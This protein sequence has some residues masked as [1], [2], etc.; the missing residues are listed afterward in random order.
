MKF[1]LKTNESFIINKDGSEINVDR[2]LNATDPN[3]SIVNIDNG[4][5]ESIREIIQNN[6]STLIYYNEYIYVPQYAGSGDEPRIP[7]Y[8]SCFE[9]DQARSYAL[10]IDWDELSFVTYTLDYPIITNGNLS[11]SAL[12][13]SAYNIIEGYLHNNHFYQ[14]STHLNIVVDKGSNNTDQ[15]TGKLYINLSDNKIYRWNGNQYIEVSS[16][17]IYQLSQTGNSLQMKVNGGTP[18]TVYTPTLTKGDQGEKGDKGDKGDTGPVGPPVNVVANAGSNIG[19]VG[20]PTVTSSQ[21]GNDVTLT[22]N[23]LKGAKGDKG[24]TGATPSIT[25]AAGSNIGS[26]G[27]PTVTSTTSGTTTTFTFNYLKGAKGDK[28]D[29]GVNATT[30]SAATTSTAGLM[31]A[32]DKA[33][34]DGIDSGAQVN[35]VTS[36]VG[37]EGNIT[38]AQ[39]ASAL[40]SA[41]HKLTDT[42]TWRGVQLNGVDKLGN[43]TD[44]G[45]LN[46]K[47]G[48]NVNIT[49]SNGAFTFNATDTTYS[50]ATTSTSGLMSATDKAKL[51]GIATGATANIGTVT[52]VKVGSTAYNPASGVVS[53]PAYPTSLPASN[54]TSTYSSTGTAPVNGTAV[55]SAIA[56]AL[57]SVLTY[58]GTIG[59]SGATVTALPASHKT[60][61]VYVVSTN[62]TYAGK[63]AEKGDFIIC[64]TAGTSANDSHWDVV[65][66]ENEVDNKNATLA[67]STTSTIATVDGTDIKVTMPSSPVT[68]IGGQTGSVTTQ[69]I[70]T[71]L[72]N[73]G[74]KLTDNNT[75]TACSTTDAGYVPKA[76]K[77]K[78]LHSNTSTGVLEWVDDNNTTYTLSG[79]MGSS[80]IGGATQPIYWNGSSFANTTYT[81][82]KSVPSNAVFTDTNTWRGI[83]DNLTSSTNTTESLS[84]K[85]GYLLANG[86]ARDNTKIPLYRFGD[87]SS[88]TKIKIKIN[89]TSSWMLCFVVTLYQGYRATKIMISGYQYG[90]NYWY[91]P[92]ARLIC[93]S[94]NIETISVYFGYDSVNNLWVGFDGGNYTGVSI[95]DVTN[96]YSQISDFSNLFTIS[97]V[98]SLTT[99]QTTI[100]AASRA[101]YANSAG[102]VAWSN[103]SGKPLTLTAATTGFTISGGTTSKTLT[104]SDNYSLGAAC[105]KGVTDN[106]SNTDVTSS[107]TNLITGRTLYYQLAKKGYTTNTGT[108]TKVSAGTGL[109]G[110]DITTTGT[111]SLATSGVTAGTYKRVTVDAYGR[112]T[113]GDNTD[114]NDNTWRK[115]QLNGTD[116]LENATNT[117][118]LN[119]KAGN[120]M[121]I[122]ESSGTFTFNATDTTYSNATTS[123]AG[124]M[125]STDKAKLDGIATGATAN[126]GTVTQVKV[127]STAYNPTNGVISLPTYPTSLPASDTTSNYSAT[128]TKPVNGTAV[129][130]ALGT[131]DVSSVGGS[132]K[133]IQSI[134]E[135]DGK[136]SATAAN[137]PS[138]L[139]ASDT[140]S[141]YSSTGTVPVNGTAVASALSDYLPLSGGNMDDS[142]ELIIG[143]KSDDSNLSGP[144][145]GMQLV[146][147]K[148]VKL[149][150]S[151]ITLVDSMQTAHPVGL[152][153]IGSLIKN[154]G[155]TV[156]YGNYSG[157][158]P[159]SN[160]T[161]CSNLNADKLDGKHASDFL[162][163]DSEGTVYVAKDEFMI[164]HDSDGFSLFDYASSIVNV[165]S[166]I[167]CNMS[168][169]KVGIN[170][171]SPS[172]PLDVKGNTRISGCL[173][174]NGATPNSSYGVFAKNSS[175]RIE[176]A[177]NCYASINCQS[178]S[179]TGTV[180]VSFGGGSNQLSMGSYGTGGVEARYYVS[181]Q[182]STTRHHFSQPVHVD[183]SCTATSHPT[184]SDE[185]LKDINSYVKDEIT[186][187]NI[188]EAPII[189]YTWKNGEEGQPTRIGTIAQYWENIIPEAVHSDE[190]GY[191]TIE[192]DDIAL[193]S[194]IISA[195][196]L[197]EQEEKISRLEKEIEELKNLLK[198]H[199]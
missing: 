79:L 32:T 158:I 49:E 157:I 69:T 62:G 15:L 61:D 72:T 133:Y 105:T 166:L 44:T 119:I 145:G 39:I 195:R 36:V 90:S 165:A 83:Q 143:T 16:P 2:I 9:A 59:S 1:N 98:S 99:L 86:S 53:L 24:D 123:V 125:S 140:T 12:P 95:N 124:L 175:F 169:S 102:S 64:N 199:Q 162:Q 75:W 110:G 48:S 38:A 71:L 141:T 176:N 172:Y 13:S 159:I 147:D 187:D 182:S 100:T 84:A 88:T 154:G 47:A 103:V 93:D 128:G 3:H 89:S 161:V 156:D 135:T 14:E 46:I 138:S 108:V 118:P 129:A 177:N 68:S 106:S 151:G 87:T 78:F 160:G 43:S 109:T 139:P 167:T 130:A 198:N 185:R 101:N 188:A 21:S 171:F 65:N 170:N 189:K 51:D 94:D 186:L 23:Y 150:K 20:T 66:G 193:V 131:L 63:S 174:L 58:K 164:F 17:N 30:T 168:T 191:L 194:S 197:K 54:T 41:N 97:N 42:N 132:G 112:V 77:G 192:Y 73:A 134:S 67:W 196:K 190:D 52:Q 19:L 29:P 31:S 37:K 85:Q 146:I 55:A 113:A 149:S 35:K 127:G 115:I 91:Q 173:A 60:G 45:S 111:I 92:E 11:E 163:I 180:I 40:V 81:L 22:F 148:Y 8:Y 70:A 183:G 142:A 144:G 80:A 178:T 179:T 28:G 117:N 27:T 137:F 6:P 184:S 50:N 10:E 107:D 18:T 25:S 82:G 96:G 26:V 152:Y 155:G 56:S 120:N 5:T 33:K 122:T 114:A 74:Y 181:S 76:I 104:V 7:S 126:I 57:T 153:P 34:L 4:L 116:K 136:I 121:S